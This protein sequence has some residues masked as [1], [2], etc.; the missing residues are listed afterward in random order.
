MQP[1]LSPVEGK[2][3]G[4][5]SQLF[6]VHNSLGEYLKYE[7]ICHSSK[8]KSKNPRKGFAG[9]EEQWRNVFQVPPCLLPLLVRFSME[10]AQ[11]HLRQSPIFCFSK[12]LLTHFIYSASLLY[13]ELMTSPSFS[14]ER[15]F[16]L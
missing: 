4:H 16:F 14:L 5:Y 2:H 1:S 6:G 3:Y 8:N 12:S 10:A 11:L 15:I 13:H 7:G 9:K